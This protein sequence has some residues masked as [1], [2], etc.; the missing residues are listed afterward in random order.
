MNH[1]HKLAQLFY[2][3]FRFQ[4]GKLPPENSGRIR[5]LYTRPSPDFRSKMSK[6]TVGLIRSSQNTNCANLWAWL[7]ANWENVCEV[8][9]RGVPL[10]WGEGVLPISWRGIHQMGGSSKERRLICSTKLWN[11]YGSP[12]MGNPIFLEC[13]GMIPQAKGFPEQRPLPEPVSSARTPWASTRSR[14]TCLFLPG[15]EG[16]L[17]LGSHGREA[18]LGLTTIWW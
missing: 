4:I 10:I 18:H 6:T 3:I 13:T 8:L 5:L 2:K 9:P 1:A 16:N 11:Q 14:G 12:K 7:P 17:H 15:A